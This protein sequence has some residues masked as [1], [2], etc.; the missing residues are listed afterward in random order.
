MITYE[1]DST[2]IFDTVVN[3]SLFQVC[4]GLLKNGFLFRVVRIWR[5]VS[6]WAC[7]CACVCTKQLLVGVNT[8]MFNATKLLLVLTSSVMKYKFGKRF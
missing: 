2:R 1:R 3:M 6:V 5:S 8:K 7:V 4:M